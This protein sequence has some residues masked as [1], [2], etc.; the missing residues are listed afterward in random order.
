LG[1]LALSLGKARQGVGPPDASLREVARSYVE[2]ALANPS[3]YDAMF[4]LA[5]HLPFGR[6]EAPAQ[7]HGALAEL[8]V[9][10]TPLAD[11]RDPDTLTEVAWSELHG[12]AT[13]TRAGRLRPDH[14]DARLA[15]LVDQLMA[16][17]VK[18]L[19]T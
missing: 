18:D 3:F 6:P 8:R 19:T 14:Q 4:T 12:L 5:T 15:L 1:E 9:A 16:V 7:L 17:P 13:L 2:F 11:D 10:V